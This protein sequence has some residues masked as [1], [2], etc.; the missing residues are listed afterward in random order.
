[1]RS[2][3]PF[4]F[5]KIDFRAHLHRREIPVTTERDELRTKVKLEE[6]ERQ[7]WEGPEYE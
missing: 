4:I 3:R 2:F 1:M 7:T 6:D 5:Q